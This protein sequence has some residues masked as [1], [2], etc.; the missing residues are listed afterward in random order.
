MARRS[1]RSSAR[2]RN[3]TRK[4]SGGFL[5]FGGLIDGV[6]SLFMKNSTAPNVAMP[7]APNVAM[8]PAPNAANANMRRKAALNKLA[9]SN[10]YNENPENPEDPEDQ[11]NEEEVLRLGQQ[12]GA[13]LTRKQIDWL[14]NNI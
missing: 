4:Q 3:K 14:A 1:R 13:R 6:K 5:G 8:P 2:R 9:R 11:I 7:P 10:Q 12:G